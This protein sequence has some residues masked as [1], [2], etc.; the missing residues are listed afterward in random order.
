[1]E[2]ERF[3]M[4]G[5]SLIR[6]AVDEMSVLLGAEPE[7]AKAFGRLE[8]RATAR[9]LKKFCKQ[10]VTTTNRRVRRL[11]A[12]FRALGLKAEPQKSAALPGLIEDALAAAPGHAEGAPRRRHP[13]R[14][15]ADLALRARGLRRDRPRARWRAGEEGAQAA[16]AEREGEA[17]SDRGDGGDGEE[18]GRGAVAGGGGGKEAGAQEAEEAVGLRG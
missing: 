18:R 15:R 3:A 14:D 11:K 13:R 7:L 2:F 6:L 4:S 9:E 8:R 1:M 16:G 5:T 12:A 10:G 17:R